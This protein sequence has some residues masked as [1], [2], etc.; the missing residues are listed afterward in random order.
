[1]NPD[2]HRHSCMPCCFSRVRLSTT[3]QTVARKAPLSMGFSRQEAWSGL[4]F[5]LQGI[6]LTQGSNP[7]LLR[8]LVGR[9]VL[10]HW[11]TWEAR[12]QTSMRELQECKHTGLH[13]SSEALNKTD[14][15]VQ[16]RK[17]SWVFCG[18][19]EPCNLKQV[20]CRQTTLPPC[21][22]Q[23]QHRDTRTRASFSLTVGI[24][25]GDP[26]LFSLSPVSAAAP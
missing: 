5:L 8:L 25:R 4:P 24:K 26:C 1:M 23:G 3:P 21:T 16:R 20:I 22:H 9:Q 11:A 18:S 7:C 15:R 12:I 6:F 10:Y 17:E 13:I 2:T 19:G 14:R